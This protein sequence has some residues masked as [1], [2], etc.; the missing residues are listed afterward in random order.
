MPHPAVRSTCA[1]LVVLTAASAAGAQTEATALEQSQRANLLRVTVE[2]DRLMPLVS[3]PGT[4]TQWARQ[5]LVA[6]LLAAPGAAAA[7]VA[8]LPEDQR[9]W[10]EGIALAVALAQSPEAATQLTEG[11][12]E[13]RVQQATLLAAR[14]LAHASPENALALAEAQSRSGREALVRAVAASQAAGSEAA[15]AVAIASE[16]QDQGLRE[17][18]LVHTV[19]RTPAAGLAAAEE[20]AGG[21]H[22]RSAR[23]GV[24]AHCALRLV[25]SDPGA[26]RAALDR[27]L[28]EWQRVRVDDEVPGSVAR[29]LSVAVTVLRPERAAS[30]AA[31]LSTRPVGDWNALAEAL[32]I[33]GRVAPESVGPEIER[34]LA[35]PE[36]TS[37]SWM[38]SLLLGTGAGVGLGTAMTEV[39]QIHQDSR[40]T[41]IYLAALASPRAAVDLVRTNGWLEPSWAISSAASSLARWDLEGSARL[42]AVQEGT[43]EQKAARMVEI[44]RG[45]APTDPEGALTR[46]TEVLR[47]TQVEGTDLS[48]TFRT[49]GEARERAGL[50]LVSGRGLDLPVDLAA[51]RMGSG[52]QASALAGLAAAMRARHPEQAALAMGEAVR[53]AREYA[54]SSGSRWALGA[55]AGQL[56]AVDPDAAW[57]LVQEIPEEAADG[58]S[59]PPRFEL[60][61][62]LGPALARELGWSEDG[63]GI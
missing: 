58:A 4:R 42:L 13:D 28:A 56:A 15:R 59:A 37:G 7:R 57:A 17:R 23:C 26:A 2:A 31:D 60:L 3:D 32:S 39:A 6:S 61:L 55:V 43:A 24:W 8:S 33:L 51:M 14:L 62:A 49:I 46:L 19:T 45:V 10:A 40:P 36:V 25:R 50:G 53:L 63:L 54:A 22:L 47:D 41:A 18:V 38:R 44:L 52:T 11:Q 34:L 16:I 9:P 27:A 1:L 20:I 35:R 12:S 29:G 48:A 21:C 5:L 30:L